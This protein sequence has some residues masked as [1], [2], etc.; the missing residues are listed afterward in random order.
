MNYSRPFRN[1]G[2][3]LSWKHGPPRVVRAADARSMGGLGSYET[4]PLP[5]GGSPEP[6]SGLGC[7]GGGCGCGGS[8]GD[9]FA[10]GLISGLVVGATVYGL[11]YLVGLGF[12]ASRG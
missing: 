2:T 3:G 9:S 1:D 7:D 10:D 8:V 5:R 12:K 11:A 6:I 4:A